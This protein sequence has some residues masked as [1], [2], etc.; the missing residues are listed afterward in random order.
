MM[1]EQNQIQNTTTFSLPSIHIDSS[2]QIDQQNNIPPTNDSNDVKSDSSIHIENTK[3]SIPIN[4][5]NCDSNSIHSIDDDNAIILQPSPSSTIYLED[6]FE[7]LPN[8]EDELNG[9]RLLDTTF[10]Q[11]VEISDIINQTCQTN[12]QLNAEPSEILYAN[13]LSIHFSRNHSKEPDTL[14][15]IH[16]S[17]QSSKLSLIDGADDIYKLIGLETLKVIKELPTVELRRPLMSIVSKHTTRE[18]MKELLKRTKD[19]TKK[20]WTEARKHCRFPGVGRPIIPKPR[21][22]RKKLNEDIVADFLQWLHA[23]DF[24]QNVAFG[25][26][27]VSY[28][29]GVHTAIEAV[30]LTANQRH[31]IHEYAKEWQQNDE[32]TML[33]ENLPDYDNEMDGCE[34]LDGPET[35]INIFESKNQCCKTC[36]KTKT[37][38]FREKNH[39]GRHSFTPKGRLSPSSIEKILSSMSAGKIRSLAG[40]DDTDSS[41]GYENFENMKALVKT[42][43]DVA[44]LNDTDTTARDLICKIDN[45]AQFHKIG[46]PRHLGQGKKLHLI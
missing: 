30:K 29:N 43:H 39:E 40:L 7:I 21:Y 13:G 3:N 42:L 44:R 31:I 41:T 14:S 22:F 16:A 25:H 4:C 34:R 27:V 38:C 46:F 36:P 8:Q 24:I 12:T 35:N 37:R 9:D 11:Q 20:E 15:S 33:D 32:T 28:C 23:N 19:V 17:E 18:N 1:N 10:C 5:G 26:K 45:V 2:I 6:N